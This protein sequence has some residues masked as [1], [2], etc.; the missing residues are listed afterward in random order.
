MS[1]IGYMDGMWFRSHSGEKQHQNSVEHLLAL[2]TQ[3]QCDKAQE[4]GLNAL[5]FDTVWVGGLV[6]S[7]RVFWLACEMMSERCW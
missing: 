1:K 5:H 2:A 3:K 4:I 7:F 6:S